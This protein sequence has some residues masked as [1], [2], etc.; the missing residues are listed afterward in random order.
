MKY[1][2]LHRTRYTYISPARDSFNDVRL[3]PPSIPEQTVES[4]SI[5]IEPE[6]RPRRYIDFYSNLVHH[7]EIHPPHNSLLIE[8][9]LKVETHWPDPLAEDAEFFPMEKIDEMQG[10]ER[11]FDFLQS[12]RYIELEVDAWKLAIDTTGERKDVWQVALALMNFTHEYLKYLPNSTDVN[13]HMRDVIA[14]RCG[15]CQDFAHFL[16]GLCRS[17]KI[18]ARYVSGYLATE[19]ASA[20]H[21]WM[22]IFVPSVGW[23]ALDPTHNRQINETYVKIGHGRDYADV[24]PVN[25]NYH[26]TLERTMEV[27]V[28]I[29]PLEKET[30]VNINQ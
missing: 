14:K 23:R 13:T 3:E 7:F 20:T 26:G 8:S 5:R 15:V 17:V 30:K 18:P 24:P 10:V 19:I 2:I 11:C 21:A 4:F 27:E 12:S 29:T 25:G 16:I 1:D 9:K 6:A 22:E 28:K